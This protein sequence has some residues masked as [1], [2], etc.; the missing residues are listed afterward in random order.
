MGT[1]SRRR[2]VASV[3]AATWSAAL[4]RTGRAAAPPKETG[5]SHE[6]LLAGHAGFQPRST[7]PLP[8]ESLAGFLSRA[9]LLEHHAAYGRDVERLKTAE[10]ALRDEGTDGSRYAELRR[11][12]VA[13]GNSV[14]LHELYFTGLA[15]ETVAVPSYVAVLVYDPYDDRWHNAIMDSDDGVWIGANPLVGRVDRM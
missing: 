2:F 10:E 11:M 8:Y 1:V 9:Q 6:G 4:A 14:L 12:Q 5:L 3:I 15:P 13:A 7:M